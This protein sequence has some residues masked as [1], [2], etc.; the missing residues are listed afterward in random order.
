MG[1]SNDRLKEARENAGF[2]SA[3]SAALRFNW[4]PSTYASHENGQ[5][6]V[7]VAAAEEYALKFGVTAGWILTGE[8]PPPG[9]NPTD[10]DLIAALRMAPAEKKAAVA[11]L[12]GVPT[13]PKEHEQLPALSR[14]KPAAK[15]K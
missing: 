14:A 7:P 10:A 8:T 4:T 3:R 11:V 13:R 5:T 6:P 9:Y 2:K 15:P 1:D 12:L